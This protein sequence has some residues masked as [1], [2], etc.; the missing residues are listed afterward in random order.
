MIVVQKHQLQVHLSNKLC[1]ILGDQM[2]SNRIQDILSVPVLVDPLRASTET[3]VSKDET[4]GCDLTKVKTPEKCVAGL[5][6]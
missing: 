3:R 2:Y 1:Y 5:L 4:R 6:V